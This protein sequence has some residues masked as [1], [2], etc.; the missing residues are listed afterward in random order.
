MYRKVLKDKVDKLEP[1]WNKIFF[2][3]AQ[4]V[5]YH[6]TWVVYV[7]RVYLIYFLNS[8]NLHWICIILLEYAIQLFKKIAD[9]FFWPLCWNSTRASIS[10]TRAC[11]NHARECHNHTRNHICVCQ[12]HNACENYTHT[13][14]NHTLRVKITLVRVEITV[15]S[16]VITFVHVK[17]T[18]FVEITLCV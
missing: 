17:V 18:M 1:L 16:V 13:W 10:H 6:V 12:N 11:R 15:M 3:R 5:S 2:S 9:L 8:P 14:Q 7:S 4:N